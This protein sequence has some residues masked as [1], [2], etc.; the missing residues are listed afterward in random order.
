MTYSDALA[1]GWGDWEFFLR[2]DG[3]PYVPAT[4]D[5]EPTDSWYTDGGFEGVIGR[6]RSESIR[7]AVRAHPTEVWPRIGA[8]SFVV[9]DPDN[10]LL[11]LLKSE[12]ALAR[13]AL[14]A[15]V[16]ASDGVIN[17]TSTAGLPAP[18]GVVYLDQE[19]IHYTAV[20]A[21]TI[22][23]GAA[24][25]TR[26]YYGSQARAHT[27]NTNVFPPI[28]P[29]VMDGPG[30]LTGR[31]VVLY[32][33]ERNSLTGDI[34]ATEQIWVGY[35]SRQERPVPGR[36]TIP[37][38]HVLSLFQ[39]GQV[40]NA[41]PKG[42]LRGLYVP[43]Y[44]WMRWGRLIVEDTTEHDINFVGLD[45]AQF[46]DTWMDMFEDARDTLEIQAGW[47]M[48]LTGEGF[49]RV[50]FD[51]ATTFVSI[52]I[53][54]RSLGWKLLGF[55]RDLTF[56]STTS[57]A[58]APFPP[59][60][61]FASVANIGFFNPRL[62]LREDE[63]AEFAE[64]GVIVDVDDETESA[65]HHVRVV[66]T[67]SDYLELGDIHMVGY[68]PLDHI[69]IRIGQQAP[70]V[71]QVWT[72]QGELADAVRALWSGVVFADSLALTYD[73]PR[74]WLPGQAL[75]D[76]DVDW[77]G[78][79]NLV[80][81]CVPYPLNRVS[82]HLTEP[83]SVRDLLTGLFL[84][85]GVYAV[86]LN[87]GTVAWRR[88]RVPARGEAVESVTSSLID[89]SKGPTVEDGERE[90]LTTCLHL[91]VADRQEYLDDDHGRPLYVADVRAIQRY[92]PQ[93]VR[94]V[95]DPSSPLKKLAGGEHELHIHATLRP[96]CE[97]ENEINEQ[98]HQGLFAVGR[99]PRD[100]LR[101]PVS[102]A[103]SSLEIDQVISVT[104]TSGVDRYA[105]TPGL[106]EKLAWILGWSRDRGPGRRVDYL[107]VMLID[108][109]L[110]NIAPAALATSWD[111]GSK[112]LTFADTD[113]YHLDADDT[114]L[115]FF[116]AGDVVKMV[117]HDSE[118]PSTWADLVIASVDAD[119][120]EV[121]LTTAP[122]LTAGPWLMVF[123]D[124]ASC[125]A[126]QTAEDWV[127]AADGGDGLIQ[128]DGPGTEWA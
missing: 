68:P 121:V 58:L 16:A 92:A 88:V 82:W 13:S 24:A 1:R 80:R 87:D 116:E 73:I 19:A 59:A 74:T 69:L 9:D 76:G 45:A 61:I 44:R 35:V 97:L 53:T 100:V 50:W 36:V 25:A 40:F 27:F 101:L 63:A 41:P 70:T 112:T 109:Q 47:H 5:D 128:D 12:P 123:E 75:V 64:T 62:Y 15:S 18:P 122:G 14:T 114:D 71:R 34:S 33:A 89:G 126:A 39:K 72:H 125:V 104:T 30:D 22:G 107:E 6:L 23:T 32:A 52:R 8:T 93:I 120:G 38:D 11:A 113:L 4:C 57:S 21:T 85:A 119:A 110:G 42:R 99:R 60:E 94:D 3:F 51:G 20:A 115:D 7:L 79:R 98:V 118:A 108:E 127:W 111:S 48:D 91:M 28:E 90:Q 10:E 37:V 96:A 95:T 56:N 31:R 54:E 29:E 26:G 55:E 46:Y 84:T 67:G 103:A 105:G 65:L 2:I 106:Y 77:D 43:N 102:P 17:V 117:T 66:N 124:R 78:L 49:V 86:V 83:K 81:T